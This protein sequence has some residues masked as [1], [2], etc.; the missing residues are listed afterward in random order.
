MKCNE[1]DADSEKDADSFLCIFMH[2]YES[3]KINSL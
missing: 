2:F 1:L 3:V